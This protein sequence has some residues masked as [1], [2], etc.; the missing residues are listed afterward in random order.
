ML[1][2]LNM[3]FLFER[4]HSSLNPP[5]NCVLLELLLLFGGGV[6]GTTKVVAATTSLLLLETGFWAM[7]SFEDA[8]TVSSLALGEARLLLLLLTT[9]SWFARSFSSIMARL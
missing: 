6:G 4:C 9:A 1:F 3:E 8:R 2:Q 7:V 5:D